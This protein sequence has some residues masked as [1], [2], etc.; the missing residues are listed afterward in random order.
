VVFNGNITITTP[1][2]LNVTPRTEFT[3]PLKSWEATVL[4]GEIQSKLL[5]NGGTKQWK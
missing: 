3:L 5:W 1:V 2:V 4:T